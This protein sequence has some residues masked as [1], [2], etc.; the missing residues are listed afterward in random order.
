LGKDKVKMGEEADATKKDDKKKVDIII[1]VQQTPEYKTIETKKV[2]VTK[3]KEVQIAA[4]PAPAP[5]PKKP[6]LATKEK[7]TF[8][9]E[10]SAKE[11]PE[12]AVYKGVLFEVGD[13]NKN[14]DRSMYDITW[15]EASV[16]EGTKKGENYSLTLKKAS[17]KYDLIV[18]PVFEG[19]NYETAIKDFQD[20][21]T[22]YN[23]VLDKRKV[24]EKKIEDDY[25]AKLIALKKQQEELERKW[26][27]QQENEFK[28]AD[29]EQ[30]VKR[31]FAIMSFGVYNCDCPSK[32]PRGIL[33][34][35]NL[36]A[37]KNR[38]LQCYETYLVDKQK[39]GLFTYS[40][41]PITTFS[42]NPLSTNMLWTVENGVLYWLKPE[43]FNSIKPGDGMR[44]LKLTRVDKTFTNVDELKAYFN[45]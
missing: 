3:E 32:Y 12:L 44:D 36:Q 15:D 23:V 22:K 40:K 4:L 13:E 27:Q 37:D 35:A 16:K 45:F 42:F 28:A 14:F 17:K 18:Y 30:K 7:Y 20:K 26:K 31:V 25:Q 21:F 8:N 19:K 10:V 41:N 29:T 34:T 9:I 39:N 11:Y 33:C 43:D 2:E 6:V 38:N 24:D 1:P 5:E